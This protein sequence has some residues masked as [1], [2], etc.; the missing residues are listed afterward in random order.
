MNLSGWKEII[1]TTVRNRSAVYMDEWGGGYTDYKDI[2]EIVLEAWGR[3]LPHLIFTS[4]KKKLEILE[5]ILERVEAR[6][7]HNHE[8]MIKEYGK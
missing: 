7:K 2:A 5:Q 8:L 4:N 3:S 6:Q 1:Y